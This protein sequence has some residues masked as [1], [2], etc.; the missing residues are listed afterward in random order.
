MVNLARVDLANSS[1]VDVD[2]SDSVFVD[3]TVTSVLTTLC[4][5]L[6]RTN[7]GGR[8]SPSEGL[9]VVVVVVVIVADDLEDFFDLSVAAAAD[10]GAM[11]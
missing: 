9:G 3:E 8:R 7:L 6:C 2:D 11:L 10:L 1:D 4:A 5:G